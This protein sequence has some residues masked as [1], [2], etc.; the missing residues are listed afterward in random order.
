LVIRPTSKIYHYWDIIVGVAMIH[1]ALLYPY[2]LAFGFP[3]DISDEKSIQL[4]IVECIAFINII[5]NFFV[6]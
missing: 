6:A 2:M 3:S 1:A 4:L 5:L